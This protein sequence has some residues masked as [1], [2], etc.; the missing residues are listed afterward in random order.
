MSRLST[1]VIGHQDDTLL[2][3]QMLLKNV[4]ESLL[5]RGRR[6][7]V[8]TDRMIEAL[9]RVGTRIPSSRDFRIP[10]ERTTIADVVRKAVIN[11]CQSEIGHHFH[12]DDLKEIGSPDFALRRASEVLNSEQYSEFKIT[13]LERITACV[14]KILTDMRSDDPQRFGSAHT[15]RHEPIDGS[16]TPFSGLSGILSSGRRSNDPFDLDASFSGLAGFLPS[17]ED[18]ESIFENIAQHQPTSIR[19]EALRTISKYDTQDLMSSS[20][21]KDLEQQLCIMLEDT[22]VELADET[23]NF[24]YRMFHNRHG[25]TREVYNFFVNHVLNYCKRIGDLQSDH[26][27]GPLTHQLQALNEF[28]FEL[29][30]YWV[31]YGERN[32]ASIVNSTIELLH[33]IPTPKPGICATQLVALFQPRAEWFKEWMKGRF[34]RQKIIEYFQENKSILIGLVATLLY[35]LRETCAEFPSV[36]KYLVELEN[37]SDFCRLGPRH[38]AYLHLVHIISIT[39]T[40]LRYKQSLSSLFPVVIPQNLINGLLLFENHPEITRSGAYVSLSYRGI[41]ANMVQAM[42]IFGSRIQNHGSVQSESRDNSL[43]LVPV[44]GDAIRECLETT[45]NHMPIDNTIVIQLLQPIRNAASQSTVLMLVIGD[46]LARIASTLEGQVLLLSTTEDSNHVAICPADIIAEFTVAK[47]NQICQSRSDDHV[48]LTTNFLLVCR[49]LYRTHE[50]FRVLSK[51]KLDIHLKDAFNTFDSKGGLRRTSWERTLVDSMLNFASTPKGM[52]ALQTTGASF[53]ERSA[54]YLFERF[55]KKLQVS[56]YEKF[57]YGVLVMQLATTDIGMVALTEAG[58]I[59]CFVR[60][61]LKAAEDFSDVRPTDEV[62]SNRNGPTLNKST[63]DC[64]KV[65]SNFE[66]LSAHIYLCDT[67][68]KKLDCFDSLLQSGFFLQSLSLNN[69]EFH[70]TT[71]RIL[72]VLVTCLDSL[73][74]LDSRYNLS[75]YMFKLQQGCHHETENDSNVLSDKFI[76]DPL[77]LAR[78]RFLIAVRLIGGPQERLL[79]PIELDSNQAPFAFSLFASNEIPKEYWIG[80]KTTFGDD[81]RFT[82]SASGLLESLNNDSDMKEVTIETIKILE[83]IQATGAISREAIGRTF[84]KIIK[85]FFNTKA[86]SSGRYSFIVTDTTPADLDEPTNCGLQLATEY[87]KRLRLFDAND[88]IG[89]KNV[90][91][92][93]LKACCKHRRQPLRFLGFDWFTATLFSI[94]KQESI[95]LEI[96]NALADLPWSTFIWHARLTGSSLLPPNGTHPLYHSFM[97]VVE[98]IVGKE[99]P[100]VSSAF[101]LSGY[102]IS[103]IAMT[104]TRQCF[105]N[106]LDW[107]EIVQYI[108][109]S[110]TGGPPMQVYFIVAILRH[111]QPT[112]L[113]RSQNE[114]LVESLKA[115]PIE[116]FR[117]SL[118]IEYFKD[119]ESRY[120]LSIDD[121]L[122]QKQ[123][124]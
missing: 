70:L 95:T 41:I 60:N 26:S 12:N 107:D 113:E 83:G 118:Q 62:Y 90:I 64:L 80:D 7:Y 32:M 79:P 40:I 50:G 124:E 29:P 44:I 3:V 14:G 97:H 4:N 16:D 96:L 48:E 106:F 22:N 59:A 24:V 47:I 8:S 2:P 74:L 108:T 35:G 13:M 92:Q 19:L 56:K 49:L 84:G 52:L 28:Q 9:Y 1:P 119:L 91:S 69:E 115:M 114:A 27:L 123:T 36:P 116:G 45:S 58:L 98:N 67:S 17:G 89:F 23:L 76:I 30:K 46:L 78:N 61:L 103:H 73:C 100:A 10:D 72:S 42:C 38:A 121:F 25:M 6:N 87:F 39:S 5:G 21:W 104:W 85:I 55:E 54:K 71:L 77:S 93:T 82:S 34:C 75:E 66:G 11:L 81:T 112:I 33:V 117:C 18:L 102:T 120:R 88:T 110:I 43:N 86:N 31:R 105:W 37:I 57:G 63:M 53:V 94:L 20:F 122:E 99:L 15:V 51:H 111:L 65:F 101:R 68:N 109:L